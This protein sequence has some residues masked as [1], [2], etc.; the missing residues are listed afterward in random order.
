MN[1]DALKSHLMSAAAMAVSWLA[2]RYHLSADQSGALL[3]DLGYLSM[4]VVAFCK[5]AS[6]WNMRKVPAAIAAFA[7]GGALLGGSAGTLHAADMSK[8]APTPAP[9]LTTMTPLTMAGWQGFFGGANVTGYGTGLN[10]ANLGSITANGNVLGAELGWETFNGMTLFGARVRGGY[11][12]SGSGNTGDTFGNKASWGG[13]V[14]FGG[15]L[16]AAL[17]L[18][19]PNMSN[20]ITS[21]FANGV[22]YLAIEGCGDHGHSG[23]CSSI[24]Y[25]VLVPNSR[26]TIIGEYTNEQLGSMTSNGVRIGGRFHW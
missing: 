19:P 21:F 5:I 10:L 2:G 16:M 3:S 9:V 26:L 18:T 20:P 6:H 12:V 13:G 1:A 14:L 23:E 24:G 4:V 11:D 22:T 8:K 17:G 7:I 15:N 25:E